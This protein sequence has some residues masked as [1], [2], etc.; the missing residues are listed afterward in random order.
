MLPLPERSR[1]L[2]GMSTQ[3]PRRP[4]DVNQLAHLIGR[5]ATGEE[6]D[7]LQPVTSDAA[8]AKDPAAVALGRKGGKKG[9][10]ARAAKM[11][12]EE[13]ARELERERKERLDAQM[14]KMRKRK[15]MMQMMMR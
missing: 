6:Q 11:T 1:M 12:P 13:R 2:R 15:G 3:R 10:A 4:S 8:P 14:K 5:I 9:G 7:E